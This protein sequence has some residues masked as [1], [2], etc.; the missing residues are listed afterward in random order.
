M[1]GPAV[2]IIAG[3]SLSNPIEAGGRRASVEERNR[4]LT[5]E[6]QH[7]ISPA[8]VRDDDR[9]ESVSATGDEITG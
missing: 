4:L 7:H 2:T 1:L 5:R 8:E 6:V 9:N 3:V